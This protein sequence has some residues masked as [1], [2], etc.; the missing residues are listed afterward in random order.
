V[1]VA[2]ELEVDLANA[3]LLIQDL[4]ND[5]VSD[6]G[7]FAS[8]ESLQHARD[9]GV[10]ANAAALAGACRDAGVPVVHVWFRVDRGAHALKQNAPIFAGIKGGDAF[11]RGGWGAEPAPGLEPA[12]GDYV[13]EKMRMSGWQDTQLEAILSG[14]GV[15]TIIVTG[16]WTNMSVE[17][18]ARTGADKGYNVVVVEDCCSS[19]NAEWHDVAVGYAL[20][21]VATVASADSVKRALDGGA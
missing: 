4:Q 14:L 16:A 20:Q 5:V 15:D 12:D 10:V 19:M 13:V 3:A 18:T 2:D 6:G 9:Q 17:H 1:S 8:D 7:A 11:V 21:N